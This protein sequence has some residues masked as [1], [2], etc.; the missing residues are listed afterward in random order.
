MHVILQVA[1]PWQELEQELEAWRVPGQGLRDKGFPH[2]G[3]DL[4][5]ECEKMKC[6]ELDS[7]KTFT[8]LQRLNSYKLQEIHK[9]ILGISKVNEENSYKESRVAT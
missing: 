7:W 6:K 8:P 2:S 5:W 3:P 9:E 4:D 1:G